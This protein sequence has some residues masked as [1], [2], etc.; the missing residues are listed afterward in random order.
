MKSIY[1]GTT[2]DHIEIQK[3]YHKK[4]LA[5]SKW[6]YGLTILYT[7]IKSNMD[8]IDI[9]KSYYYGT[10]DKEKNM[11]DAF[12]E[13]TFLKRELERNPSEEILNQEFTFNRPYNTI[14]E[15]LNWFFYSDTPIFYIYEYDK[16]KN[17]CRYN[18][19]D[20]FSLTYSS[21]LIDLTKLS[22]IDAYNIPCITK[23]EAA[24]L[25]TQQLTYCSNSKEV[26]YII[27]NYGFVFSASPMNEQIFESTL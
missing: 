11:D 23:E 9:S 25:L 7:A 8:F 20:A 18:I 27:E 4:C 26:E 5:I 16:T 14:D 22:G 21:F 3:E 24:E 13:D 1:E 17:N 10:F 19:F 6:T 2:E 12:I 15:V